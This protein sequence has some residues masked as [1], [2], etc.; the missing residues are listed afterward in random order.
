MKNRKK[1]VFIED[2][3]RFR[4]YSGCRTRM[5]ACDD[6]LREDGILGT[7]ESPFGKSQGDTT[8]QESTCSIRCAGTRKPL[9][10]WLQNNIQ[11]IVI[12]ESFVRDDIFK[13]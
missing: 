1:G 9:Q 11:K 5:Y 8:G 4:K 12:S 13:V 6:R 3:S 7:I 10:R 2:G